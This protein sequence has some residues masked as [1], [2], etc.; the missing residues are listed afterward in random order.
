MPK[1]RT[2]GAR[3]GRV[4]V[5]AVVGLLCLASSGAVAT[6]LPDADGTPGSQY[7]H[8]TSSTT[9]VSTVH[10]STDS[11]NVPLNGTV[12]VSPTIVRLGTVQPGTTRS[13]TVTVRNRRTRATTFELV[14][15]G[16]RG[17]SNPALAVRF[18]EPGSKGWG[19]TA[20]PWL[21]PAVPSVRL[22]PRGVAKVR[23]A[24]V[25][26]GDLHGG[27]EFAALAVRP[28]AGT[29]SSGG[30]SVGLQGE[31]AVVVLA[32]APG[33]PKH[34]L[35][36]TRSDLPRLKFSRQSWNGMLVLR[37]RG[38][39][40]E[41]ESGTITMRNFFTRGATARFSVATR[42]MLPGGAGAVQASWHHVPLLGLYRVQVRL[43]G[44]GTASPSVSHDSWLM[45]LPP[46][47]VLALLV[48]LIAL[49]IGW[50][51]WRDRREV[52]R[53]LADDDAAAWDDD[54]A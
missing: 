3:A 40:E 13:F 47:W 24:V 39:V 4:T 28:S 16:V 17:A 6:T 31:V 53:L 23:I 49:W 45:V 11:A 1:L 35:E 41:R 36:V 9:M 32:R 27:G 7:E 50:S 33:A 25:V 18:L 38:N 34:H 46:W 10:R 26:P 12:V 19:D 15:L 14:P 54:E 37:N 30:A 8:D 20:A 22:M 48:V 51:R 21:H 42:T 52:S 5:S 44:D 2:P 43:H 29:A